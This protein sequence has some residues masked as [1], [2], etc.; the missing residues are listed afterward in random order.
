[1]T[2]EIFLLLTPGS[3]GRSRSAQRGR[4]INIPTWFFALFGGNNT[5]FKK[6]CKEK[7]L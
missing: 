6:E 5:L 3:A 7:V 2:D 4:T 1:M